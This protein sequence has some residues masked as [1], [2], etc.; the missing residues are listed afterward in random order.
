MLS[1]GF[2]FEPFQVTAPPR[3]AD[4]RLHLDRVSMAELIGLL[5]LGGVSMDGELSG[6]IP[7]SIDA[8][9]R[10]A[11]DNARLTGGTNGALRIAT[12]QA[13]GLL[14]ERGGEQVDLMLR[15]LEDFR[16][17]RLEI[18]LNKRPDGEAQVKVRL[19]GRNPAVLDE[20][21]FVFNI[22]VEGNA[23]RLA[24]TILT[25]YRAS[26]GVIQTGVRTLQ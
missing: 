7:V 14:G 5:G 19:E 6:V 13:R 9:E 18:D 3:D 4:L 16:Y 26:S 24:E 15:A 10:V 2:S 11:I 17:D 8:E 21:P 12:E 25:V 1:G 22:S 20:H 23:D